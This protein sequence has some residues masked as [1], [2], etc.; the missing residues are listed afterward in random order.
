MR[1]WPVWDRGRGVEL[2][3]LPVSW[4]VSFRFFVDLLLAYFGSVIDVV[5]GSFMLASVDGLGS[6]I[7]MS[8]LCLAVAVMFDTGDVTRG[9]SIGEFAVC[10]GRGSFGSLA[11]H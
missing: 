10:R 9:S 1:E 6:I 5:F 7:M 11:F 4:M 2:G 3:D 8:S